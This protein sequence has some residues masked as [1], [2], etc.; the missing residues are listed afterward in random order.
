MTS[1]ESRPAL[2]GLISAVIE[3]EVSEILMVN[4]ELPK[5]NYF[6][7][8]ERFDVN[9]KTDTGEQ[10]NIEMQANPMKGDNSD[11]TH[12]NFR[13]RIVVY[14]TDL[15]AKQDKQ[16]IYS[17]YKKTYCVAFCDYTIWQDEKC[18]RKFYLTD[19]DNVELSNKISAI[20]IELDKIDKLLEK[21]SISELNRA[22]LWAFYLKYIDNP[23]YEDVFLKLIE[24]EEAFK[25]ATQALTSIS[26]NEQERYNLFV[27]QKAENDYNHDMAMSEEIGRQQGVLQGLFQTAKRMLNRGKS[28]NEIVEDTGLTE[29]QI[30]ALR[31]KD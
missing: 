31:D 28:V 3:D 14:L 9:C 30:N 19:E 26:T 29:Q 10:I 17:N 5:S 6:E 12:E 23:E 13:S 4:T 7:K 21:K 20:V 18:I 24:S 11:N 16:K 2:K 1:E 8:G 15:F 22:E 27:R 25:V